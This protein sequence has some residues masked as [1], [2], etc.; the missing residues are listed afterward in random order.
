MPLPN[1]II[2]ATRKA[3]TTSLYHYLSQ[4][5]EIYMS[6]LKGSRFF[7]FDPERPERGKNI[8]VKSVEDYKAFFGGA[9]KS[10]ARAIGEAS[11]SYLGSEGAAQRISA[12]IPDVKLIASLRNPVDRSYSHYLMSM[13]YRSKRDRVPLSAANFQTW[14]DVGLYAKNLKPWFKLFD[15]SQF[16]IIILEEWKS[17]TPAMLRDLHRF[18]SV[19]EDFLP[20]MKTKYNT[21]GEPRSRVFGSILKPRPFHIRL[22]PYIPETL[23][24]AA[25]RLRNVNM[26]KAPP[27]DPELRSEM[28]AYFRDDILALQD[29]TGLDL[30]KWLGDGG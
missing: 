11:P 19:E 3:G 22:K 29:M 24:A 14:A 23:R 20:D 27:L 2:F 18:L 10:G 8:P 21:G 1:F 13:R 9:D 28:E 17:D 12:I 25:N 4:H 5:P 30:S 16:K 7:L 15:R 6:T 26:K